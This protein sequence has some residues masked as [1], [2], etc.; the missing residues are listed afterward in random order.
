MRGDILPTGSRPRAL[1][2]AIA[3]FPVNPAWLGHLTAAGWCEAASSDFIEHCAARGITAQAVSLYGYADDEHFEAGIATQQH[4][5]VLAQ[6]CTVDWTARQYG[7]ANHADAEMYEGVIPV[8]LVRDAAWL[9]V[10]TRYF[11]DVR[12]DRFEIAENDA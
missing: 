12:W 4:V 10:E 1:A 11:G 6:G 3:S 7:V 2:A 9:G 8:P 5:I